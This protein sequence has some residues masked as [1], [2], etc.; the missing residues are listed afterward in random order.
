MTFETSDPETAFNTSDPD[1]TYADA[2]SIISEIGWVTQ[3]A[4]GRR[5]GSE[6]G[7][8]F[9]LRK[10]ALLDRIALQEA[11]P[12]APEVAAT[13]IQTAEGAAL[14]LIDYDSAHT[15]LSP[16]GADLATDADRRDY[17]REQYSNWSL[18]QLF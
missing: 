9:W 14:G 11:A 17:V 4:A 10:A 8:E 15:G 7:R 13:A 3:Q 1:V 2:P 5:L 6:L 16:R 12:Y 18:S